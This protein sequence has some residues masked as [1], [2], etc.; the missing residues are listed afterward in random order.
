VEDDQEGTLPN[1]GFVDSAVV[2]VAIRADGAYRDANHVLRVDRLDL[3]PV[4]FKLVL[5]DPGEDALTLAEADQDIGL[6]RC[7]LKLCVLYPGVSVVPTRAIDR[8]WHAHMLDTAKYRADCQLVFGEFLDHFPYAGLQGE[9]DRLTWLSDFAR[10]RTLFREHFRV[11]LGG[12]PGASVC[13]SH[14]GGADCCV[15]CV[16]SP[17]GTARPRPERPR[18]G[19]PGTAVGGALVAG[20]VDELPEVGWSATDAQLRQAFPGEECQLRVVR[21]WLAAS[22]PGCPALGDLLSIVTE[23][24]SNAIRHSATGRDGKFAVEVTHAASGVLVAVTDDGGPGEPRVIAGA[25]GEHGRGLVLV[26]GLSARMGAVGGPGGRTVW[27]RIDW[28]AHEH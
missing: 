14:G 2:D 6:Y 11:E 13:R 16:A 3:E 1:E 23:L 24:G 15:G 22:L 18:D 17:P 7:F 26:R 9:G 27:A 8:V 4:V 21:R 12:E 5:P 20:A 19:L 10:T 28:D 25:D